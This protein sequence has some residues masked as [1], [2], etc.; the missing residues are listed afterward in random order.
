MYIPDQGYYPVPYQVWEQKYLDMVSPLTGAFASELPTRQT[1]LIPAAYC[2]VV[3]LSAEE[4]LY[5]FHLMGAVRSPGSSRSWLTSWHF[6]AWI[7]LSL[8]SVVIIFTTGWV[9]N[10]TPSEME[11]R[12]MTSGALLELA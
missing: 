4:C 1:E 8:M 6:Y 5:W 3:S 7:G 10:P 2:L 9:G 12:S 11:A